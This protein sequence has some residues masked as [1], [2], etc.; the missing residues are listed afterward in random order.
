MGKF[1]IKWPSLGGLVIILGSEFLLRDVFIS[2]N[3]GDL[4][5]ALHFQWS[6]LS[7]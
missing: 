5:L 3:A 7:F 2:E 6:G 4:T 1:S